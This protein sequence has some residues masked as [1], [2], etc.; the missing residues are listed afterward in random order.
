MSFG[1][2]KRRNVAACEKVSN[3]LGSV[4]HHVESSAF[5]SISAEF[6]SDER[7]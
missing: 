4:T 2:S 6:I 1:R 7:F 3:G 5:D